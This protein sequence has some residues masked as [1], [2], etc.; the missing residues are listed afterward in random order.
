MLLGQGHELS[1]VKLQVQEAL[2][3]R[4]IAEDMYHA[5]QVPT[6]YEHE[7]K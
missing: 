1:K 6:L 2:A 5:L 4:S 7:Y 3:S